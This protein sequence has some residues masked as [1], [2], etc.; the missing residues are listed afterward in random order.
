M[1]A[2][3]AW[4]DVLAI[5]GVPKVTAEEGFRVAKPICDV[6]A[7]ALFTEVPR[8]MEFSEVREQEFSG[9]KL[10]S[11]LCRYGHLSIPLLRT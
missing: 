10:L 11:L 3:A 9:N 4:D 2:V 7:T 8:S 5:T 1:E 6:L